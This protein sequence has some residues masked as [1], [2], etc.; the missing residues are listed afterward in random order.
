MFDMF[1]V[2]F[3]AK[4]WCSEVFEVQSRCYVTRFVLELTVWCSRTVQFFVMFD[5]IEVRFWAKMWCSEVFEVGSC[6]YV[7]RL[8]LEHTVWCSR[9]V[10]FFVMFDMFEVR[11]WAKMWCSE[12]SMFGHSMFGVFE[13]RY[14]GVRSKT[15]TATVIWTHMI[16]FDFSAV[17][18]WLQQVLFNFST[19]QIGKEL[20]TPHLQTTINSYLFPPRKLLL[21]TQVDAIAMRNKPHAFLILCVLWKIEVI[22]ISLLRW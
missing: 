8:V 6:C 17:V 2:R 7:T 10:R 13:V 4:M 21:W 9:T 16:Y 22:I 3:W 11:F 19:K 1:E 18:R 15:T 14:F 20:W 5:M 12:S